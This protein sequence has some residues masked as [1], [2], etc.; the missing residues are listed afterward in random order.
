MTYQI[1]KLKHQ[2]V[3]N[4]HKNDQTLSKSTVNVNNPKTTIHHKN[5]KPLDY[6]C[7]KNL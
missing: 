4:P 5:K 6:R 7:H 2:Q 1:F 3:N